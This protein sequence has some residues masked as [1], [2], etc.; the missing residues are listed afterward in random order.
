MAP[1]TAAA[2]PISIFMSDMPGPGFSEMPPLSKVIPF[3]TSTIG[4]SPFSPPFHSMMIKRG[5][6]ALPWFTASRP[7]IPTSVIF[8]LSNTV[9]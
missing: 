7:P 3:P 2:P 5:S 6:M 8:F 1:I 4:F 9:T